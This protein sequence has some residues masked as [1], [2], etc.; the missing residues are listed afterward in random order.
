MHAAV[1]SWKGAGRRGTTSPLKAGVQG[2]NLPPLPQHQR[3]SAAGLKLAFCLDV[4]AYGEGSRILVCF[5]R[6]STEVIGKG[7]APGPWAV[8][9]ETGVSV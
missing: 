8:S 5:F 7:Q 1:A 3:K 4:L 2:T 6:F 9:R